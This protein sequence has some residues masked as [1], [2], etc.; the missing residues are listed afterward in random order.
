[1][2]N[3]FFWMALLAAVSVSCKVKTTKENTNNTNVK[4]IVNASNTNSK[5]EESNAPVQEAMSIENKT[6]GKVSHRYRTSG[7]NTVIEIKLEG[8]GE[9]QTLIPKDKLSNQIDVDGTEI[10]F[11]FLLLRMPQPAGCSVGQPA[12]ITDIV[13]KKK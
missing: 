7:C 5:S 4:P 11:N 12:D 8:E 13:I 9:I 3:I 6:L 10:Y 2:K 1:M